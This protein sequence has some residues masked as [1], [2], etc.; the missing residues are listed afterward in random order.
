MQCHR[1]AK[2]GLAGRL[3]LVRVI[4][5]GASIRQAAA[6]FCVYALR[7]PHSLTAFTALLRPSAR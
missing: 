2:I 1:N 3:A 4:E 7:L 5:S 6:S